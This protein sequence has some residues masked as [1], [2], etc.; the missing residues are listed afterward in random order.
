MPLG[1]AHRRATLLLVSPVALAT[2]YGFRGHGAG[3]GALAA[4]GAAAWVLGTLALNPDMDILENSIHSKLQRRNILVWPW[5]LYWWP[6]AKLLPHRSKLSHFPVLGTIG[7]VL[8]LIV[9]VSLILAAFL[10]PPVLVDSLLKAPT[11]VWL[12]TSMI[13]AGMVISDTAH[14]LMD[15]VY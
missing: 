10:S 7:R 11:E 5:Y 8:Y 14:W 13:I 12:V 4:V 9:P 6:Y 15:N 1:P 2:W 3:T